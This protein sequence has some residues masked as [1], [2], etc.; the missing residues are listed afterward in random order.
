MAHYWATG[1]VA[2][3]G[4]L[5]Q[6]AVVRGTIRADGLAG[7]EQVFKSLHDEGAVRDIAGAAV[8]GVT[9]LLKRERLVAAGV[10]LRPW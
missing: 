10:L 1:G 7:H 8:L 3:D 2:G 9:D 6:E 4:G 5:H